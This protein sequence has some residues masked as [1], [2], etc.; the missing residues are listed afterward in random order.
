V[1]ASERG[2]SYAGI[3]AAVVFIMTLVQGSGPPSSILP[4]I[5]RFAG[6]LGGLG[7]MLVMGL[8]LWPSGRPSGRAAD[9][10]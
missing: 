8:L 6:I 2:V 4:G 7:V 5:E 9:A 1:Q 10:R 3:Q